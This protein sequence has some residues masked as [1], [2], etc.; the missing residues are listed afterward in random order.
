VRS[1]VFLLAL[2][3][4]CSPRDAM[5]A[6]EARQ[7]LVGLHADD[8]RFCAGVADRQASSPGGEFWTYLRTPASPG[9]NL[10]LPTSAGG[11]VSFS[12]ANECRATFHLRD[13]R[14]LR[15]GYSTASTEDLSV[16]RS[17]ACAVVVHDCLRMLR[18]R[19]IAVR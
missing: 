2:A 10:N 15:V 13:D 5:V 6:A 3:M 14:V 1:L 18:D 19:E 12:G 16:T 4:G 11:G 8:L 17:Q 7:S 9:L